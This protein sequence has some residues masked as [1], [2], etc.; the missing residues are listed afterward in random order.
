MLVFRLLTG[1]DDAAF[2]HRV[3]EALSRGWSLHGPPALAYDHAR[4]SIIAGQAIT[5]EV[6][7]PYSSDLD[8]TKL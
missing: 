4:A 1:R 2:C 6:D 5:K 8:F 3:T 7:S